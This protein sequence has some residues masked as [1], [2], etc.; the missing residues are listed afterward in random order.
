MS[1]SDYLAG[2]RDGFNAPASMPATAREQKTS[3]GVYNPNERA[4]TVYT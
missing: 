4:Y 2:L 1:Y 3:A